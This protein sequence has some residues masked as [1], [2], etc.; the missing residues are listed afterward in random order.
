MDSTKREFI[1]QT[2]GIDEKKLIVLIAG[3]IIVISKPI[4]I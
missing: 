3:G 2:M 4:S 1:K